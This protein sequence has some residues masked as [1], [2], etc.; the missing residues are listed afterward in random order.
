MR[1]EI[2]INV[3][4]VMMVFV[5]FLKMSWSLV[6]TM[7]AVEKG[8]FTGFSVLLFCFYLPFIFISI[9]ARE[10]VVIWNFAAVV[11]RFSELGLLTTGS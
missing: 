7:M 2:V 6:R 11:E 8:H 10:L 1:G 3:H 9:K 4:L 5:L